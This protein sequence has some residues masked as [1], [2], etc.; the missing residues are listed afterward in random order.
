MSKTKQLEL[1]A[2]PFFFVYFQIAQFLAV[3]DTE[4]TILSSREL[5]WNALG[6][7][8]LCRLLGEQEEVVEQEKAG[9][10]MTTW[11]ILAV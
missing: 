2:D 7:D 3:T 9:E 10:Q 1:H 11:S 5:P 8:N 4:I 6:P